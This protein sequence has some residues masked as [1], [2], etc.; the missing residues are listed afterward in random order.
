[1]NEC[2][3]ALMQAVA[4]NPADDVVRGVLA[5]WYEENGQ[6][7]RAEFIRAQIELARMTEKE[8]QS[9]HGKQLRKIQYANQKCIANILPNNIDIVQDR[10]DTKGMWYFD[11]IGGNLFCINRGFVKEIHCTLNRWLWH[12]RAIVATNPIERVEVSDREPMEDASLFFWNYTNNAYFDSPFII[13]REVHRLLKS[14]LQHRHIFTSREQAINALS[15]ALI[16]WA[17]SDCF[18]D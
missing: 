18:N 4:A 14:D 16:A 10:V 9:S 17:L 7:E 1:M 3:L 13:P 15:D 6:V 11:Y 2:E 12:G 8:R 5:D